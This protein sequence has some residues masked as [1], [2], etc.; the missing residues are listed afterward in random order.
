MA[1]VSRDGLAPPDIDA[2]FLLANERTLLAWIRTALTLLAVGMGIQ[3]FGTEVS[4]RRLVAGALL[5]LGGVA[6]VLGAVRYSRADRAL[7]GGDLPPAA[8]SPVAVAMAVVALAVALLV[9]VLVR[10]AR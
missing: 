7:R 6:A 4:A 10:P 2:R 3:Q 9:A 8:W 1:C 5:A